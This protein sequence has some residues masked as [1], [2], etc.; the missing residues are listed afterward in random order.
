MI[1]FK[2]PA[3][4]FLIGVIFFASWAN[5]RPTG[6][7]PAARQIQAYL[8][9][10]E[11]FGFSGAALVAKNGT[12]AVES[13]QGL[14]NRELKIPFSRDTLLDSGSVTKQFTAAAILAL[15]SDGKLRVGDPISKFFRDVPDDKTAITLHHLLTHT[16]GLVDG[17]GGDYEKVTRDEIVER[18]LSSQ[19]RSR[20]G[21]RHAYSNVG[22]SLLA[23]IIEIVSGQGYETLLRERLFRRAGITSSGYLLIPEKMADR[24][25]IGYRDGTNAGIAGRAAATGGQMWNLIGNGGVHL[26]IHDMYKWMSAFAAG[27]V[28]NKEASEKFFHPHVV[29]RQNY[30]G[31]NNPL[32]YAY[33]WYVWKQPSGKT[34]IWH[35]GGN[36][37]T[38]AAIRYHVDDRTLVVYGS[39]VSEYHDPNYPVPAIERI[40]AG[41]KVQPPPET[42]RL[43][44]SRLGAYSGKYRSASGSKIFVELHNSALKV[45]GEGQEAFSFVLNGKWQTSAA[46]DALNEHTARAVEDSRKRNF[47]ALIKFYGPDTTETGLAEFED[48]FWKKR[49]TA[50][51]E[52]V[53]T[54]VLGTIPSRSKA[55]AGTTIAAIDFERGVVFREYLWKPEG[56]IGDLGPLTSAPS[57]NF[58]AESEECFSTFDPSAAVVVSKICFDK[59]GR[60]KIFALID[61]GAEKIRVEKF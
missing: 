48:L 28:L 20:P 13:Y 10:L 16:A 19:L 42:V 51:G 45:R 46:F 9:R 50:F 60:D 59:G 58:Y 40:L 4:G 8:S 1:V 32:H 21:E 11:R 61:Q 56:T 26:S 31:S 54:R 7:T 27:K 18:S 24:L 44:P 25:A 34:L 52:Y 12:I 37:I 33:G 47:N 53:G 35:L 39:N 14:A 29:V 2:R 55:Y 41:E 22:Y 49:H 23:A 36:G 17:F 5:G 30:A 15:E 43:T 38:N 6:D 57:A 3:A